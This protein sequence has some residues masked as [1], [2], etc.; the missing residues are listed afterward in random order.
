MKKHTFVFVSLLTSLSSVAQEVIA[1]QGDMYS[2][3]Q[4]NIN[5]TIGEVV[6]STG[7]DGTNDITQGFHQT[8][9]NFLGI[10]DFAPNYSVTIYPNPSSEILT[11]EAKEFEEV[12]FSLFDAQGKL[13]LKS[14]LIDQITPVN[15]GQLAPG[16]Y[17][18]QLSNESQL[19]KTFKLLKIN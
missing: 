12:S 3:P 6:M 11:I 14:N 17:S 16:N 7:T 10:D 18:L 15:V 9:L 13:V 5:F 2:N 1:T 4:A 8:N 19:L